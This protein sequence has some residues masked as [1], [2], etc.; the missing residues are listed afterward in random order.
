MRTR[1]DKLIA[2]CKRL[3][4]SHEERTIWIKSITHPEGH[5][6]HLH[7]TASQG[8]THPSLQFECY[9]WSELRR[10]ARRSSHLQYTW[11]GWSLESS[12]TNSFFQNLLDR[13]N[14]T[15]SLCA[16][17]DHASTI[18]NI[19]C[20]TSFWFL[21]FRMNSRLLWR[22]VQGTE[23]RQ[24]RNYIWRK[25]G[26]SLKKRKSPHSLLFFLNYVTFGPTNM[27]KKTRKQ[28]KVLE[29]SKFESSL[30]HTF[31]GWRIDF[32]TF[33][34]NVKACTIGRYFDKIV[35]DHQGSDYST[36]AYWQQIDDRRHL[37]Y[38]LVSDLWASQ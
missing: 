24:G 20:K 30:I 31:Q 6:L 11:M 8:S 3:Y 5:V 19:S 12:W 35:I 23:R 9:C 36:G 4:Q 38:Y 17:I 21:G 2:I 33:L 1:K 26:V 10:I 13:P 16:E 34:R 7:M 32:E 18:D 28:V 29:N 15:W 25:H 37:R 22:M 27:A 14:T